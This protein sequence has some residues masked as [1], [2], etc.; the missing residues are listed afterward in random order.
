MSTYLSKKEGMLINLQQ[1]NSASLWF[2]SLDYQISQGLRERWGWGWVSEMTRLGALQFS[3]VLPMCVPGYGCVSVGSQSP[4]SWTYRGVLPTPSCMGAGLFLST[5]QPPFLWWL[6]CI[7][8]VCR[9]WDWEWL[10]CLVQNLGQLWLC[11]RRLAITAAF[12]RVL[13]RR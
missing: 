7:F 4:T 10:H 9:Q 1:D 8:R 6:S 11:G 3:T 13:A 5:P 2:S 12:L